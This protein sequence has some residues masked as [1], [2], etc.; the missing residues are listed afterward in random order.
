MNVRS[1]LDVAL[2]EF[3]AL[4][5]EINNRMTTQAAL[6]GVGLTALG[7]IVGLV[8]EKQADQRLL[9]AVPPLALTVNILWAVENRQ[10]GCIGVYI[11]T[12]LWPYLCEAVGERRD[13]TTGKGLPSWEQYLADR[14]LERRNY[15]R[16]ILT[17]FMTTTILAAAAFASL[18]VLVNNLN[19]EADAEKVNGWLLS[20][21]FVMAVAALAIPVAMT[22]G[23]WQRAEEDASQPKRQA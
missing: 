10:I 19:A 1:A 11:R 7:V 16:S 17:D 23:N 8:V 13:P 14:R 21:G 3:N 5:A 4:R 18:G 12:T 22:I 15:V 2:A 20:I 9:L 6:V